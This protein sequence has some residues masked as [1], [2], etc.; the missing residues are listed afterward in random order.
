MYDHTRFTERRKTV[1]REGTMWCF[2]SFY[3]QI[4]FH[5]F[6]RILIHENKFRVYKVNIFKVRP[7]CCHSVVKGLN[8]A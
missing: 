6:R 7:T 3:I 1:C 8:P 2:R 4:F 5:R